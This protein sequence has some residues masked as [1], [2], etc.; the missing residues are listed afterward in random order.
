MNKISG[1][2]NKE[3]PKGEKKA[4]ERRLYRIKVCK[5]ET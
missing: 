5:K 3:N 2:W 4:S 1:L